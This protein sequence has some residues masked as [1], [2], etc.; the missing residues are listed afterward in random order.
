MNGYADN[1]AHEINGHTGEIMGGIN[2]HETLLKGDFVK[3][4]MG[5]FLSPKA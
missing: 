3:L 1:G 2:G 5:C 4:I